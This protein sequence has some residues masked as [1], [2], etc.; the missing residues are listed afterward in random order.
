MPI[1]GVE[2]IV[3]DE[4]GRVL[5]TQRR[6]LPFWCL[7]GGR[8]DPGE[9][10]MEAVVREVAEETGLEVEVE[11]LVGVYCMPRWRAGG[12][13]VLLFLCRRQGGALQLTN[14]TI[15]VGYFALDALPADLMPMLKHKQ[16]IDDAVAN[17]EK[18]FLR[19]LLISWPL[20]VDEHSVIARRLAELDL[21]HDGFLTTE[22]LQQ[23]RERQFDDPKHTRI[24]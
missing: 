4:A 21:P 16:R 14:E 11:R 23:I 19:T 15:D 9:T 22:L 20:R 12:A 17:V 8:V 1:L 2:G 13:T 10:P 5:L 18:V 6:D 3:F 24:D 7:P